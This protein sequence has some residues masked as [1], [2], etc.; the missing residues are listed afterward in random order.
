MGFCNLVYE[1]E[2]LRMGRARTRNGGCSLRRQQLSIVV[3]S[4]QVRKS[5]S[6]QKWCHKDYGHF[7]KSELVQASGS[8]VLKSDESS[9]GSH[10]VLSSNLMSFSHCHSSFVRPCV[11]KYLSKLIFYITTLESCTIL[12]NLAFLVYYCKLSLKHM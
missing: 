4:R 12:A 9:M 5:P 6:E 7:V 8:S 3:H 2:C 1:L 11:G 10:V